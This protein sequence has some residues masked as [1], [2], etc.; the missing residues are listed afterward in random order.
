MGSLHLWF[1][2]LDRART[3]GIAVPDCTL[4]LDALDKM[5]QGILNRNTALGFRIQSVRTQLC[6]DVQPSMAWVEHCA[7]TLLAGNKAKVA[8]IAAPASPNPKTPARW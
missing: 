1:R 5:C 2:H 3:M 6:L 8:A 7:R 4:I